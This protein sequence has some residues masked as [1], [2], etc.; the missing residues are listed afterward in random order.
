MDDLARGVEGRPGGIRS[1]LEL[2]EANPELEQAL[3]VDVMK[4]GRSLHFA[5]EPG[6]SW[7][8]VLALV[9]GQWPEMHVSRE[10]VEGVGLLDPAVRAT[11][12]VANA[13]RDANWQRAGDGKAPRPISAAK[14]L[15]PGLPDPEEPTDANTGAA[16]KRRFRPTTQA[17]LAAVRERIAAMQAV[18]IPA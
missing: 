15:Y 11:V 6:L 3:T 1:L 7:H 13:V 8:E 10:R 14:A 18:A 16:E 5:G 17:E 12:L 4:M 9:R 2:L